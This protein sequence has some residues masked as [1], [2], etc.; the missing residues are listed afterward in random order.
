MSAPA[1]RS[2]NLKLD[3]GHVLSIDIVGYPKLHL[4]EQT[5]LIETLRE[6]PLPSRSNR[7]CR[8]SR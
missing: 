3:I 1:N 8:H 5:N 2:D 4:D 6:T 7:R